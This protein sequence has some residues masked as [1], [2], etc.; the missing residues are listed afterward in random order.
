MR[1]L[2][3]EAHS[4]TLP[5]RPAARHRVRLFF[6]ILL[7]IIAVLLLA[8]YLLYRQDL[9]NA[10]KSAL[11]GSQ[12]IDTRC[13]PIEYASEGAGAPVLVLHGTGG[14]WDQGILASSGLIPH[15]FRVIAPSRFG[16]LRTA[17]PADPS[18]QAEADTW[19]CFLDALGLQRVPVIAMSAGATPALQLAL[20]HPDRVSALVLL[21][22]A[23][24]GIAPD[25]AVGPSPFLM[26]VVLRSDFPFWAI[27]KVAPSS[28]LKIVAVPAS[29]VPALR[30]QDRAQLNTTIAKIL[31]VSQRRLGMLNDAHNQTSDE[32]FALERISTPTLLI[33]AEDDLYKTLPNAQVAAERIPNAKL[34][35]FETGGHL[36]LGRGSQVWPAVAEFIRR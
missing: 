6:Q 10:R 36:L 25:P 9:G 15:G 26:N 35:A 1:D 4:P 24:G 33:S 8:S 21:V 17:M 14:G 16:Y 34:I 13:G 32:A 28:M 27:M 23:S 29:L 20:R 30:P 19:P 31:P 3:L 12:L 18:P 7:L 11:V 22:P 5:A 2:T